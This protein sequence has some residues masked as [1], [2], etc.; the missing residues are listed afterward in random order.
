MQSKDTS[1]CE[2]CGERPCAPYDPH[3]CSQCRTK[4]YAY[5][6][7]KCCPDCGK[8]VANKSTYCLPCTHTRRRNR[9]ERVCAECGSAYSSIPSVRKVFCSQACALIAQARRMREGGESSPAFKNARTTDQYGY[10]TI[11]NGAHKR[12][13]YEHRVIAE[14]ALGRPLRP[15]ECVH[16]VNLDKTD[17]RPGNLV[18]CTQSY[19]VWLHHR[20]AELYAAEHFP[21]RPKVNSKVG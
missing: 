6:K 7:G 5:S 18:I 4:R 11:N 14:R 3:Y 19:H 16:H 2:A 12:R 1:L 13:R 15:G 10:V 21:K 17:N 8:P 9:V 20:M